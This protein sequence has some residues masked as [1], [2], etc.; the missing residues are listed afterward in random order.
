MKDNNTNENPYRVLVMELLNRN[1]LEYDNHLT[2][3]VYFEII[4]R[5]AD[6]FKDSGKFLGTT[7]GWFFSDKGM[8]HQMKAIA[9][10][11]VNMFVRLTDKFKH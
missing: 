11:S 5:Y 1:F 2:T 4:V 10:N 3:N 8:R 7:V 9:S 6:Y